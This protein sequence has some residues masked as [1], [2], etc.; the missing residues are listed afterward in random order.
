MVAINEQS[1]AP[2]KD[3]LVAFDAAVEIPGSDPEFMTVV[4]FQG[5]ITPEKQA[6]LLSALYVLFDQHIGRVEIYGSIPQR[7][8]LIYESKKT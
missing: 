5:R 4:N 2:L 7:P 6:V 8:E 3:V 1:N